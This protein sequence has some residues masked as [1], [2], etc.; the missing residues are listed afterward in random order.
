MEVT[1]TGLVLAV[2]AA[3]VASAVVVARRRRRR[4]ALLERLAD[5]ARELGYVVGAQAA[6]STLEG[7]EGATI[8]L[9]VGGR[10]LTIGLLEALECHDD[11]DPERRRQRLRS[12]VDRAR[13]EQGV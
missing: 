1:I 8:V 6:E 13:L 11:P 4:A 9:T 12:V 3:G 10:R 7:F 2:L 5:L